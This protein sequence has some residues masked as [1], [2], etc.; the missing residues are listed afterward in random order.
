M[1]E[2][3][4]RPVKKIGLWILVALVS[5]NM[6]G[7][8]IFL[9]PSNLAKLGSISLLS[10]VF[11]MFGA[12][13]LALV[14]SR[15]STQYPKTG[16]PYAYSKLGLGRFIGFQTAYNY[17]IAIWVGNAALVVAAIGYLRLF[18]PLLADPI[19]ACGTSIVIVWILTFVNIHGVKS[20]G[21]IQLI[22]T[23]LKLL[24]LFFIAIVGWFYI[25]PA[26]YMKYFNV[27]APHR[28]SFSV[29][30]SGAA[31]TFWA[32][33]GLES[34][35]VPA[36]SVKNPRINI[37][38]ATIIGTLIAAVVY[39]A[40][41]AVIMG[42]MPATQLQH[43]TFPFALAG[44]IILGPW[45]GYL[46]S[47]GAIISCLGCLNGWILLQ[48]Q[49]PM[50]TADDNLF[51]KIFAQRN[52][53]G[54]PAKGLIISS[55]LITVLLLLTASQALV[56]QFKMIILLATL[57][58]LIPYFYTATAEL[59][60]LR[61]APISKA[62]RW[63]H[64]VIAV[65]AGIFAFWGSFSAGEDIVYF[66]TMLLLASVPLYAWVVASNRKKD[67][68]FHIDKGEDDYGSEPTGA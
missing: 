50:A 47:I 5:G 53:A 19:W 25:H 60:L 68:N 63:M 36:D 55:A 34:A 54:V 12:L 6:I 57:A 29:I 21:V 31:L 51:P 20:A 24:P 64:I 1:D 7:S 46:V 26:F 15:L 13:A 43:S 42:M 61:L 39:I 30:S 11:T 45:G 56:T 17:W 66:G 4:S 8:G 67:A 3:T 65:I 33:I 2:S 58:S 14:F 32:F 9:L 22:S 48:G 23:V 35:T 28:S 27:S 49:I 18:F 59:I 38:L 37:P 16:G 41:S 52:K 40:S 10:W 44:K 62:K